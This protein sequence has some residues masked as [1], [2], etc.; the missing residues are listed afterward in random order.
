MRLEKVVL[1]DRACPSYAPFL[2]FREPLREEAFSVLALD[3]EVLAC[4]D[5]DMWAFTM[6]ELIV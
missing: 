1:V 2:V 5:H 6:G 4:L 3:N